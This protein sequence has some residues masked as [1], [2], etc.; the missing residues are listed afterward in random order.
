MTCTGYFRKIT[1]ERE[2]TR[3]LRIIILSFWMKTVRF[4]IS[5]VLCMFQNKP[6]Q[7]EYAG[8]LPGEESPY[9]QNSVQK[10]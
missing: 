5:R 3:W 7:I 2:T 8:K 1:F 6:S 9:V 10:V 4:I